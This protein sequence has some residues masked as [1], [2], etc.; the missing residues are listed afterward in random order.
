MIQVVCY[1]WKKGDR[2]LRSGRSILAA[3]T[4]QTAL[5]K[6]DLIRR[7]SYINFDVRANAFQGFDA[8]DTL[9]ALA[10]NLQAGLAAAHLMSQKFKE[11]V[12][13]TKSALRCN[14]AAQDCPHRS[15]Y[16]NHS[17]RDRKRDW[18]KDQRLDYQRI[19]YCRA[20][21]LKY[22][23]DTEYAVEHM[24]KALTFDPGDGT[25][26]AQLTQLRQELEE[27]KAAARKRRSEKIHSPQNQLRI[28]QA[29]RRSKASKI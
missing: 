28:K 10:L 15:W 16:C 17:Y 7:K 8:V 18:A 4:Y 12:L 27:K 23:G 2:L 22:L 24:E 1:R 6:I 13:S 14:Q 29:K 11:V 19:H 25:A 9:N 20:I 21:A 5:S 3:S 26:F